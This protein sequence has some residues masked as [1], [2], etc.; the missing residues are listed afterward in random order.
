MPC[1]CWRGN[2]PRG[3][4]GYGRGG[5]LLL[6]LP[7]RTLRAATITA[8]VGFACAPRPSEPVTVIASSPQV[9][10]RTREAVATLSHFGFTHGA[11]SSAEVDVFRPLL[12]AA[13]RSGLRLFVGDPDF[14]NPGVPLDSVLQRADRMIKVCRDHPACAGYWLGAV[15]DTSLLARAAALKRH[16]AL[17]DRQHRA[18]LAIRFSPS[19]PISTEKLKP[20]IFEF[21][22][23]GIEGGIPA[24]DFFRHLAEMRRTAIATRLQWWGIVHAAPSTDDSPL[25]DHYLRFQAMSLLAH[26]AT[27][28]EYVLDWGTLH[29]WSTAH[30]PLPPAARVIREINDLAGAWSPILTRTSCYAVYHSDPVPLGGERVNLEGTVYRIDGGYITVTFFRGKHRREHYLMVLNRNFSRGSKPTL[31]FSQRVKGLEEV[32]PEGA[33]RM[34]VRFSPDEPSRHVAILLK[35]GGGRLFRLVT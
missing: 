12:D 2:C 26:G 19:A 11:V 7:A 23:R 28:L 21:G 5:S 4:T 15:S 17:E 31:F 33:A 3:V 29:A 6:R 8:L 32:A 34:V 14:L 25:R 24:S 13:Q 16:L 35:A 22:Q 10:E 1:R 20:D 30:W 27:G 9:T 18:L